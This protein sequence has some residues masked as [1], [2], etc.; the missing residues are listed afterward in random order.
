MGVASVGMGVAIVGVGVASDSYKSTGACA[1][2][3]QFGTV[4]QPQF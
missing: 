2:K 4:L 1:C 3:V